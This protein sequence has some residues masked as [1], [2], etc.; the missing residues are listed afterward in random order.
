MQRSSCVHS[1]PS[2]GFVPYQPAVYHPVPPLHAFSG[3]PAAALPVRGFYYHPPP[4]PN[5]PAGWSSFSAH[6]KPRRM[7]PP[8]TRSAAQCPPIA[9]SM[10]PRQRQPAQP[11]EAIGYVGRGQ[12][13]S[14]KGEGMG[15]VSACC[16]G[17]PHRGE[18]EGKE[19]GIAVEDLFG[20]PA[21]SSIA[22]EDLF[23]EPAAT[24]FAARGRTTTAPPKQPR[25][26]SPPPSPTSSSRTPSPA[27]SAAQPAV[28]ATSPAAANQPSPHLKLDNFRSF[29]TK[30]PLRGGRGDFD[31]TAGRVVSVDGGEQEAI[32]KA[33]SREAEKTAGWR[34]E[35]GR[36]KVGQLT[37]RLRWQAAR[38]EELSQEPAMRPQPQ[39]VYEPTTGAVSRQGTRRMVPEVLAIVP[40]AEELRPHITVV[41]DEKKETPKVRRG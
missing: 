24:N 37:H 6:P 39:L 32:L 40:D 29:A 16:G 15:F 30:G 28:P 22:V 13:G 1:R 7:V 9:A 10:R 36:R 25:G 2:Y 41:D 27:A 11:R 14:E 5:P 4:P 26:D 12:Q 38:L 20:E 21:H 33:V 17:Q 18:G 8:N 35:R 34:G 31:V 3:A 19:E 23:S